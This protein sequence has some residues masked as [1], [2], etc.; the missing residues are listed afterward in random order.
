MF[1]RNVGMRD[2]VL[3]LGL[4]AILLS[5]LFLV[6]GPARW[7]GLVGIIPLVTGLVGTCPLYSIAGL[8]TCPLSR[9]RA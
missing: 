7:I 4:A 8:N 9:R 1:N 5:M 2:R 6:E 3:R